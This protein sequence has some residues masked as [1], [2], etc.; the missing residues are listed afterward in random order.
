MSLTGVVRGALEH[1]GSLYGEHLP[2]SGV[3]GVDNFFDHA[4]DVA[5]GDSVVVV[6]LWDRRML[7][8]GPAV[9]AAIRR[10]LSTR[11]RWT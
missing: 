10:R 8:Q 1:A 9:D 11:E 3:E 4:M 2:R 5:A 6:V 7:A